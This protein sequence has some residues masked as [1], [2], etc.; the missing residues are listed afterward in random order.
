M[1]NSDGISFSSFITSL[2]E[3]TLSRASQGIEASDC[4]VGFVTQGLVE[5]GK[6]GLV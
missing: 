3:V 1:M 2:L 6:P 4:I 5:K